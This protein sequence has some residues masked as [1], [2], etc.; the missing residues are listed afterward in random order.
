MLCWC[1]CG[2]CAALCCD[3][4]FVDDV[5]GAVHLDK[6]WTRTELGRALYYSY[7][8]P[9]YPEVLV[10][11]ARYQS[12]RGRELWATPDER[13]AAEAVQNNRVQGRAQRRRSSR[14]NASANTKAL[15][16]PGSCP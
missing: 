2:C 7:G 12:Y 13:Q 15:G 3:V 5:D 6:K 16:S 14:R 4:R 10:N 11:C 9:E 8:L 1:G